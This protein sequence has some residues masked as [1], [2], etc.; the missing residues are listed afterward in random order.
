MSRLA[1]ASTFTLIVLACGADPAAIEEPDAGEPEPLLADATSPD[2][3]IPIDS[4]V[5]APTS[6]VT[7][8]A[9]GCSFAA[10]RKLRSASA[11]LGLLA[12]A[13][14]RRRRRST[15]VCSG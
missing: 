15:L 3:E 12:L 4:A 14:L 1:L 7:A 8:S 6:D 11:L 13:L 2:A 9:C 5:Q 10:E